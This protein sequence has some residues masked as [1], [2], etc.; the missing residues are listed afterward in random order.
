MVKD[1]GLNKHFIF[2]PEGEKRRAELAEHFKRDEYLVSSLDDLMN[3]LMEYNDPPNIN[4]SDMRHLP[5]F[6]EN[7]EFLG[8]I[9]RDVIRDLFY[10]VDS[11][12]K[13]RAILGVKHVLDDEKAIEQVIYRRFSTYIDDSSEH[14]LSMSDLIAAKQQFDANSLIGDSD[15]IIYEVVDGSLVI[16]KD[17]AIKCSIKVGTKQYIITPFYFGDQYCEN[18]TYITNNRVAKLIYDSEMSKVKDNSTINQPHLLLPR[19]LRVYES[20]EMPYWMVLNSSPERTVEHF[21]SN[22]FNID[23]MNVLY[24]RGTVRI[25][26][27]DHVS[28]HLVSLS[29]INL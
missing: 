2:T 3:D 12:R 5:H 21:S 25:W 28:K 7:R 18:Q 15:R 20:E 13:V 6:F 23:G 26:S 4:E 14:K 1:N 29:N 27:D 19:S 22:R 24:D 11:N 8:G 9:C 17:I 10:T 16:P